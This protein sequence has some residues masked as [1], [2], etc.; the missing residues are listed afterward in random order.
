M[1]A[2]R[3]IPGAAASPAIRPPERREAPTRV[4]PHVRRSRRSA[5]TRR[6]ADFMPAGD[7][8]A[9]SGGEDWGYRRFLIHHAQLAAMAGGVDAFLI[10]SELR[11]LTTLRDGADAFPFV[12]ALCALAADVR[13]VLGAGDGDH[14]RRRLE[15]I[16]RPPA[17][18]RQR[19]RLFPPRSAVGARGDR[20]R[21]HRQLHAAGGLAR[22]RLFGRRRRRVFGAVRRGRPARRHRF[23][24]RLRLV[25][26]QRSRPTGA[27]QN[28][29]RRRRP[30]Q[31]LGVPLQGHRR[32][33][34]EPAFRPAGRHRERRS[35]RLGAGRQAGLVHRTRLPRGRQGAEPAQRLSRPQVGGKRAA[36]VFLR[37]PLRH[38]AAPVSRGAFRPL[39]RD[40]RK[41]RGGGQPGL[42]RL[43]RA[44][45]GRGAHLLLGMGRAPVS[46]L[47]ATRRHMGRRRRLADR[48]LAQR[49]AERC[50]ARRPDRENPRR[51][52]HRRRRH[53]EGRGHADRLRRLRSGH[54]AAGAG[55]AGPGLRPFGGGAGRRAQLRRPERGGRAGRPRRIR[56]RGRAAG[57]AVGPAGRARPAGRAGA[58]LRRSDERLPGRQRAR[59]A[60]RQR[61]RPAGAAEPRS[62]S[63]GGAGRKPRCRHAAPALDGARKRVAGAARQPAHARCRER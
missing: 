30:R 56:R 44:H 10:G 45:G 53:G 36:V 4:R 46:R 49:P 21:R 27:H 31:A 40:E 20:R 13:T 60:S 51:P 12:E 14:L 23:R 16:F 58:R 25:L 26:C 42:G 6:L 28:A 29:D 24:R 59:R 43:W 55:A 57:A 17:G 47:P 8:V 33:V 34:G 32:V 1:R 9:F 54:R 22:R 52:R 62:D 63:G 18:R 19:R 39:G 48:P 3:P 5:A 41:L 50:R 38:R 11:G 7:T 35:H 61:N 37:R 15:R 2:S